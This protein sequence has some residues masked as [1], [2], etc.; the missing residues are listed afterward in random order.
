MTGTQVVTNS[1]NGTEHDYSTERNELDQP[2]LA[3]KQCKAFPITL[4]TTNQ[5]IISVSVRMYSICSLQHAAAAVLLTVRVFLT[6]RIASE[7]LGIGG[8]RL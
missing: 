8:T 4:Q 6:A 3:V 1:R 5:W 2:I 7:S